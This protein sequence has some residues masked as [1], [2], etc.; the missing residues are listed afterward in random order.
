MR[1][2]R[3]GTGARARPSRAQLGLAAK[4]ARS[5][6]LVIRRARAEAGRT[7]PESIKHWWFGRKV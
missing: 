5:E 7:M 6:A 2:A 1:L 3:V 4:A